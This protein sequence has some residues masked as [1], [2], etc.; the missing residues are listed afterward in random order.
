MQAK[1][2]FCWGACNEIL[3]LFSV[4]FNCA[5]VFQD[6][7]RSLALL[8]RGTLEE[9]LRWPFELYDVNEDGVITKDEMYTVVTSIYSIMGEYANPSIDNSTI[10]E[11]VEKVFQVG[12]IYWISTC[13]RNGS[14]NWYE[15][16]MYGPLH[17]SMNRA[18]QFQVPSGCQYVH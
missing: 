9:K 6:F 4:H 1:I 15:L 17:T 14:R 3:W 2:C 13:A 7:V 5:P 8:T 10:N 18:A 16:A 11:H 12:R